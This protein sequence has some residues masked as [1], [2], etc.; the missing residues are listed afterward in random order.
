MN[1]TINGVKFRTLEDVLNAMEAAGQGHYTVT[2]DVIVNNPPTVEVEVD[3]W[4]YPDNDEGNILPEDYPWWRED[5]T[6]ALHKP[7]V[8]DMVINPMWARTYWEELDAMT[9]D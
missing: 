1:Y 2:N 6:K 3:L 8:H 5:L 7:G 4:A 9:W